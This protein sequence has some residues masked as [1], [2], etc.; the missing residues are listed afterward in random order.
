MPSLTIA[1]FLN[2]SNERKSNSLIINDSSYSGSNSLINTE[3]DKKRRGRANTS[4]RSDMDAGSQGNN[5]IQRDY[6]SDDSEYG[7]FNPNYL[8]DEKQRSDLD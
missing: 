8:K 1:C 5:E 7:N 3:K 6:K 2:S 4:R